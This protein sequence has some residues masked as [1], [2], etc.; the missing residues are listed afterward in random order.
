MRVR[1]LKPVTMEVNGEPTRLKIGD[2]VYVHGVQARRWVDQGVCVVLDAGPKPGPRLVT[3]QPE[4]GI[5]R[6][7][8]LTLTMRDWWYRN[9]PDA[10]EWHGSRFPRALVHLRGGPNPELND[11][12]VCQEDEWLSRVWQRQTWHPEHGCSVADAARE[13]IA[14]Q[15]SPDWPHYQVNY[16]Y[17]AKAGTEASAPRVLL[18]EPIKGYDFIFRHHCDQ[19]VHVFLRQLAQECH[20]DVLA[21]GGDGLL[22]LRP[23]RRGQQRV[24]SGGRH[25]GPAQGLADR[26]VRA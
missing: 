22:L 18:A 20:Y 15:C 6:P 13:M 4:I 3:L 7:T 17:A 5:S 11:C 26:H 2:E 19:S 24:R 1:M 16:W 9:G 14:R 21:G 8:Q 23:V 25:A 10:L 12:M